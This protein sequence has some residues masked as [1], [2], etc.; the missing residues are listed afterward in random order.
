MHFLIC[1]AGLPRAMVE[2][3]GK[4]SPARFTEDRS[5]LPIMREMAAP[6]A[7]R[8]G[9]SD[10][11]VGQLAKRLEAIPPGRDLG[12]GL[13]YANHAGQRDRFLEAFYPFA[14]TM[15]FDPCYPDTWRKDRKRSELATAMEALISA[16][17]RLRKRIRLMRDVLSG[18]NFSPLTLPLRNF[19]SEVLQPQISAISE[20]L[21]AEDATRDLVEQRV[22]AIRQ[23]HPLHRRAD[24][25]PFF[26]DNRG[27][28]F[29][30]P[31]GADHGVARVVGK[32]HTPTCLVNGRTRLGGPLKAGFH[33]DCDYERRDL[34]AVYPNCH[35]FKQKP[36]KGAYVNI[37]PTDAIR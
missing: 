22:T 8:D 19:R 3:M 11:F 32:G 2:E 12:V 7:Y 17:D 30:S 10:Y 37:S 18:Q 6:Y 27:L 28:R 5:N 24:H 14:A 25:R 35:S 20:A 15:P 33:Y 21:R 29:L 26:E 34:D 4:S 13:A 9:M 1:L 23:R 16:I 36:S 31:G